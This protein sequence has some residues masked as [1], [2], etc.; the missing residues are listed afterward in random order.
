MDKHSKK[1]LAK[2][3]ITDILVACIAGI[4]VGFAYY[5]FQNSTVLSPKS[6]ILQIS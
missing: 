4:V 3:W 6:R 1:N 2:E 5:F